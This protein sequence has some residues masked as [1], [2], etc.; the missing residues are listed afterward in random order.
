MPNLI[1]ILF[2]LMYPVF[3]VRFH[4]MGCVWE[5]VWRLKT[6][7]KIKGV[8]AG[9]SREDFPQSEAMCLAHD[10]NA[11]SHDRWWQ[12]VF[13]SILRVRPSR[14]IPPKHSILLFCHIWYTMFLPTL[15]L[16]TYWWG[17]WGCF[18]K[19]K[20]Y[21]QPLRIKDCHTH[22]PLHNLLWFSLT[23]TSPYPNPWEV[24]SLNT[25]HTHPVCKVRFW[26][27]WEA[28]EKVICL[29]DAI[30][31]NCVIWRVR[32]DKVSLSQLVAGAWRAQVLGI[33]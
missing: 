6:T 24:D 30:V 29:V 26:C 13:A 9:S 4:C 1:V 16:P 15:Y 20:P 31:M 8:F 18:S 22:N 11:K 25:Y 17:W 21:P 7:L 19:R 23:L 5:R 27:Y 3:Y 32:E 2:N 28:L 10:W 12:L 14:E 33:D